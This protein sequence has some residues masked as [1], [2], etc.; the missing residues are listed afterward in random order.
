MRVRPLALMIQGRNRARIEGFPSVMSQ[1]E[2]IVRD[3]SAG[4]PLQT[5]RP[6]HLESACGREIRYVY[7]CGSVGLIFFEFPVLWDQVVRIE[8]VCGMQ[9]R[10]I[11]H[12][13]DIQGQNSYI[14][15]C[16]HGRIKFA[17]SIA[18]IVR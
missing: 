8:I 1:P 12:C 5:Y 4:K 6:W 9:S 16:L 3:N 17:G 11:D 7:F 10:V 2:E 14:C 18:T 13:L 15:M